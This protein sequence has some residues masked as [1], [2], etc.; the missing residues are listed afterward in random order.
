MCAPKASAPAVPRIVGVRVRCGRWGSGSRRR[1]GRSRP[2]WSS[3]STLTSLW[4]GLEC[5]AP[6][7]DLEPVALATFATDAL[8][9]PPEYT[10]LVDHDAIG[11]AWEQ[12]NGNASLI[13]LLVEQ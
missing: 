4:D 13:A 1:F 9:M 8:E 5:Y 6:F 2:H 10:G 7:D 12:S 11:D 3:H